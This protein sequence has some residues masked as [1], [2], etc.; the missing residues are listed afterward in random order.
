MMFPLFGMI[1]MPGPLELCIIA[2]I[3]LLLFGN[4]LPSAMRGMGRSITEF[5]SGMKEGEDELNSSSREN[6][7]QDR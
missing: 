3:V 6:E 1:G 5:K 7:K 2:G 4:R